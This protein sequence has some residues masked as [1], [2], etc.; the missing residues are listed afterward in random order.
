MI[1]GGLRIA[2]VL[3]ALGSC[4]MGGA[5]YA[6][7]SFVM[8]GLRRLPEREG[9]AAMQSINVT[10]VTPP[11]MAGFMGT[12]GL[13]VVAGVWS[14][15]DWR[16]A[17]S[18]WV[19]VGAGLY[20]LGDFLLTAAYHVPRNDRLATVDPSTAEGAGYWKTYLNEW[21]RWNHVR[22]VAGLAAAA[23]FT[24]ALVV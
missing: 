24:L 17:A 23:S 9:A 7:S 20:L 12:T 19:L 13:C 8:A 2:V 4:L 3:A 1:D 14:I 10:A 18:V 6:F 22:A 11:F 16:G 21:T 15:V 5:F